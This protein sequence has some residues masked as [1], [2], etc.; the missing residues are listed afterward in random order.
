MAKKYA[1]LCTSV[2]ALSICTHSAF[3]FEYQIEAETALEHSDNARRSS[4]QE[5]SDTEQRVEL[6]VSLEEQSRHLSAVADY[7]ARYSDYK[8][9]VQE[10]ESV[11]EGQ[12]VV[13]WS[14]LPRTLAW[15]LF[16]STR[17]LQRDRRQV[18]ILS[19][20]EKRTIISTGPVFSARL[21]GVDTLQ[22]S[23]RFTTTELEDS[24]QSENDR[25]SARA[26]WIHK[27]SPTHSLSAGVEYAETDFD[28]NTLADIENNSAYLSFSSEL[29]SS[30]LRI[31]AGYNESKRDSQDDVSGPLLEASVEYNPANQQISFVVVN[32][33]TD[34]TIGLG[35][36]PTLIDENI[37]SN[38]SSFNDV[39]IVERVYSELRYINNAVCNVCTFSGTVIYDKQDFDVQ[40]RDESSVSIELGAMYRFSSTLNAG[41]YLGRQSI[42]FEDV[43]REDDLD[44]IRIRVEYSATNL[45]TLYSQLL[46]E[47]RQSTDNNA[48]YD[49]SAAVIGLRYRFH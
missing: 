24:D 21:S 39:D 38:D 10:D 4:T 46:F 31:K 34:S 44:R 41:L 7:R 35:T 36:N 17:N 26:D 13:K 18:D 42:D 37:N 48:D 28:L 45:L 2:I 6:G 27:L 23:G 15:D 11:I 29:S 16:T 14:P 43:N 9:N 1:L 32:L 8:K 25:T 12:A 19:N 30:R 5:R 40:L 33:I 47:E 49:E 22:L 3:S 20:R